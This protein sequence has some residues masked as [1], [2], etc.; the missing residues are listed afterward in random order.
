MSVTLEIVWGFSSSQCFYTH[1]HFGPQ[2]I[3][4]RLHILNTYCMSFRYF[5]PF[6]PLNS[7][8]RQI[9]L[10]SKHLR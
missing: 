1:G 10:L 9:L 3:S 2:V 5:T 6:N 8:V 4:M 7:S